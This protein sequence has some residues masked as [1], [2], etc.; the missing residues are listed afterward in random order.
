MR[1]F[2]NS[3]GP[4]EPRYCGTCEAELRNKNTVTLAWFAGFEGFWLHTM[5]PGSWDTCEAGSAGEC[6]K[7]GLAIIGYT[8]RPCVNDDTYGD[9]IEAW[10]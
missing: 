6:A 9:Q 4:C 5:H 3:L 7:L 1:P 10:L 8:E 2:D